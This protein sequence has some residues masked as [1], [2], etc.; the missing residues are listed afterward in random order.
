MSAEYTKEIV[1]A[2]SPKGDGFSGK[3]CGNP[4]A[5][6]LKAGSRPEVRP[7]QHDTSR[8]NISVKGASAFAAM[9]PFSERLALDRAALRACLRSPAR[10]N[11]HHDATGAFCLVANMLDDLVPRGVM[12]GFG[13]HPCRQSLDVQVL[14]GDVR[15]LVHESP[16]ELVREVPP[17][18][19]DVRG[20]ASGTCIRF[21]SRQSHS[22]AREPVAAR[23]FACP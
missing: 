16:R 13:E 10:I 21:A 23:L 9:F 7:H 8:R 19:S 3:L 18:V 2:P 6:R 4:L 15:M 1:N 20:Q 14:K 17:L 11:Q 12:H 22:D 5:W